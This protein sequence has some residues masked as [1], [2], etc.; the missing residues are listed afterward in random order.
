MDQSD[1]GRLLRDAGTN[2]ALAWL[3]VA[4]AV[5]VSMANLALG[6]QLWALFAFGVALVGA[7]PALA[8]RSPRAMPPWEVLGLAAMPLLGRSVGNGVVADVT[9]YLAVAAVALLV[10]VE[11]DVFTAVEMN[12]R[13]AVLFVVVTTMAAAGVWAVVRWVADI[14]LGTG[15]VVDE[16]TLMLEFVASTVAGVGAGVVF[17]LYFRRVARGRERLDLEVDL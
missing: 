2:A 4:G 1:V 11:L 7:F 14:Y 6:Q 9:T 15:F 16:R 13:F 12:Y 5:V 8:R 17:E 10:A 3:L